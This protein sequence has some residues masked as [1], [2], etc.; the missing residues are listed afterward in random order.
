[1]P[2]T[3][4]S[5]PHDFYAMNESTP[6]TWEAFTAADVVRHMTSSVG[7]SNRARNIVPESR[8]DRGDFARSLGPFNEI[9]C[10]VA[11]R[12]WG[13]GTAGTAIA[14]RDALMQSAGFSVTN[15]PGTSNIYESDAA[16]PTNTA[17]WYRVDRDALFAEYVSGFIA[18]QFQIALNKTDDPLMTWTGIASRKWEFMAD[19]LGAE[20]ADGV[21]T[22]MTLANPKRLR[23]G[24]QTTTD[25]S[26][27]VYLQIE[28]EVVKLTDINWS[29]GVCTIERGAFSS[30]PAA[31]VISTPVTPYKPTP[32]YGE[33]GLV[34]G[35]CDWTVSDGSAK[36]FTSFELTINT[37]RAFTPIGSGFCAPHELK[38]QQIL[39]T[40]S[41]SYILNQTRYEY[42]RDMDAGTRLDLA[43]TLGS[44][45]GSIFTI[46]LDSVELI[47]DVPKDLPFNDE[48]EVTQNFR[49]LDTQTALRGQFKMTET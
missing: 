7:A 41:F 43:I 34:M 28:S 38:N 26:L 1:M 13:S 24:V 48:F 33:A 22:S 15:N 45:A 36:E 16:N 37:G 46:D 32:T 6:F 8:S 44:T 4:P 47:D 3:K 21:T 5:G 18:Q 29:T 35:P 2:G 10:N 49:L 14:S 20:I 19:T 25:S 17:S 12:M 42:F 40:G 27:E 23:T 11:A 31:H 30:T 39:G 9:A